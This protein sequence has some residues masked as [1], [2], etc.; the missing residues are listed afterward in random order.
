MLSMIAIGHDA[1]AESVAP[2]EVSVVGDSAVR[3]RVAS[4]YGM[5]CDAS[6]NTV[7][8]NTIV[9][10]GTPLVV[11]NE[12]ICVC[13]EQTFAP[14]TEAG[15]STPALACRPAKCTGAGKGRRCTTDMSAPF[16]LVVPSKRE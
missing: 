5:P 2:L 12:D 15:W 16:R 10:P 3:V 6:I 7:L 8:A 13:W 1:R 4:G 14:Y 9:K 11:K